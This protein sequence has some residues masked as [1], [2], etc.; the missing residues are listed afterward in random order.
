MLTSVLGTIEVPCMSLNA[1][2]AAELEQMTG[3]TMDIE[4][5]LYFSE[6]YGKFVEYS[7]SSRTACTAG[8]T[9]DL[10]LPWF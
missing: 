7:F 4:D 8:F 1:A 3:W 6:L 10:Q 9:F 5:L 2:N